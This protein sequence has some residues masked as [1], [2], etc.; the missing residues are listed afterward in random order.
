M[1]AGWQARPFPLLGEKMIIRV[2]FL[3]DR[4]IAFSLLRCHSELYSFH[5]VAT[6]V[7][8]LAFLSLLRLKEQ[9]NAF[10]EMT[11]FEY[12]ELKELNG[13]NRERYMHIL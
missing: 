6:I 13:V 7:V 11:R 9:A 12:K 4:P 3:R 8:K 1:P 10:E 5:R 2:L